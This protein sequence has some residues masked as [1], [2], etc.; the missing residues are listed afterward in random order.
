M[1]MSRHTVIWGSELTGEVGRTS[2][3]RAELLEMTDRLRKL[4]CTFVEIAEA[5]RHQFGL[6]ARV[7]YRMAH[8][9]SQNEAADQWTRLWPDDRKIAKRFSYWE[10]WPAKT[11][12]APSLDVFERL[13]RLY[14]CS[15][16]DL[17]ADLGNYRDLDAMHGYAGG[18]AAPNL[19]ISE[20]EAPDGW[21]VKSLVTLLRIDTATPTAFEERTIIATRN[22]IDEIATSMSVPRHP[23]DQRSA[24]GLEVELLSGGRLDLREQPYESQFRHVV[25]LAAPL[26]AGQEHAYRLSIQIPQGQLMENHSAHTP[27]QRSDFFQLTV[28]FSPKHL[29]TDLWLLSGVPPAVVREVQPR[30]TTMCP[31]RF[32]EVTVKFSELMQGKA[33][34]LKWRF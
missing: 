6:N 20:R 32:G 22:G 33:Y 9:W 16:A 3:R 18:A 11:G 34:G 24:H 12:H 2:G 26:V 5:L 19:E 29:P 15:V 7:A 28:R 8:G 30:G 10:Q 14:Q 1:Y 4:G 25:T 17:L 21:Y 27:L 31:D 23:Y 13:A